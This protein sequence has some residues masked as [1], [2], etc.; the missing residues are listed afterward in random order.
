MYYSPLIMP[1]TC[2]MQLQQSFYM[3]EPTKV[4]QDFWCTSICMH[5][6][7]ALTA[8]SCP[9]YNV[10]I[11]VPEVQKFGILYLQLC[12]CPTIMHFRG[13]AV[14]VVT[15]PQVVCPCTRKCI[16]LH[17]YVAYDSTVLM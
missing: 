11:L 1:A 15:V 12:C 8:Y 10:S 7:A 3:G 4:L 17:L 14:N 2:W 13:T 16:V 5:T 9:S 6:S